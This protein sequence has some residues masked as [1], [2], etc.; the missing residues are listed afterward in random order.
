MSERK[1]K[2]CKTYMRGKTL[3]YNKDYTLAIEN[4]VDGSFLYSYCSCG[5][6]SVISINYCPMCR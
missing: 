6:H 3:G 1:C 4:I 2:F 5:R